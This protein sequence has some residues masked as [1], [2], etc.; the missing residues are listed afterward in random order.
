MFLW[1][2][3]PQIDGDLDN[4][5]IAHEYGH[6]ISIRLVGGPGS[7]Q[8]GGSEQMGEGWSDW[9]GLM[10]TMNNGDAG[11]DSRA[12]GNYAL[13]QGPNGGGIRPTP[14]STNTAINGTTYDDIGGLSVPHGV[15]YA[16]ATIIWDLTWALVDDQGFDTD[17]YNGT[18]G[19]NV[20]M[21][22]I[23][24]GLK[25]TANNPGFVSGR[26][27]IL[28]ADQ[29]LYGG[30][31]N[32]II[33][34]VFAARG[35]GIDANEN[36]NGGTN[37][38]TDQ[39]TS[40]V[41]GCGGGGPE[42]C[43]GTVSS[44][45][46]NESF[47][48]N[49]G[50]WTQSSNDDIDWTRDS[51]GT[52]SSNTGPSSAADGTTYI[53]VEASVNGT[54]YPNKRAILNSPC[55]DLSSATSASFNY[56]YHMFGAT[57][58]G[59]IDLEVSTDDGATWSSIW[60]Q[61]GNQGDQ[62]NAQSINLGAYTGES[63]VRLRF[64]RLTGSTWQADIALDSFNLDISGGGGGG[65]TSGVSVPYSESFESSIGVW[66][67]SLGDDIDWT[68][69]S[70]GTPSSNTGPSSGSAG[71]FYM[72][73][74]ASV[75][76]TGYPNKRAILNSP[77]I[78]L[79]SES[80]AS[81]NFD[82]HMFGATD[83]GSIALE[84]STDGSNWVSL[85]S[86]T[87]NQGNQWNSQSIDLNAYLGGTVELRFNR[88][89]GSTWQADIAIDNVSLTADGG[90]DPNPPTGYCASNGNNTNDEY[91]QRVEI[92]SI[93]NVTGASS[94]GYGD[95]TNLSTNLGA[96]N[97]ITITPL[98]TGTIYAEGYAVWVD[99][100]RDGDFGDSGELVFSQ[101]ATTDTPISGSFSVPGG[102]SAGP[103]RMR[104]SMKYNGIPSSCESFTYGEVEDYIVVIPSSIQGF[105]GNT[106]NGSNVDLGAGISI[107]PNPV[108]RGVLNVR[109]LDAQAIDY[110]IYNV[111]GQVVGSGVFTSSI[112]VSK[113]Q[114][115]MYMIQVNAET[116]QFVES[117]IVE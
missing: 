68:R 13:G 5:I 99:W 11:T 27:G 115:G 47:E 12:V 32:C 70:G 54:G 65:C 72:Y 4:L 51:G 82:Y 42:P 19:N 50:A 112:D 23:I 77:C 48:S 60:N 3:S 49:F 78:D 62:W 110:T 58:M 108:N 28:Q 102:A 64:N 116:Q 44:Y 18:G 38:N 61:T 22:L 56:S 14:Y 2:G 114:S 21:S 66:S 79:T 89:T 104:V 84:A 63:N 75:N 8:L 83:M 52:P 16:W 20:A 74:E 107:S 93:D 35:V 80:E 85:W 26:D 17:F 33:W 106:N 45:P 25:N 96:S 7:N 71:S 9:F 98:W 117:F 92:G 39:T 15:G 73:V 43:S 41:S 46:Y 31:Y 91:I 94:G 109:L 6:G 97:S 36:T 100:N 1:S 81:F 95:Y 40:F 55:F 30:Q 103:T 57:D 111:V 88:L 37:G 105:S 86:Q 34:D 24:E 76:G 113:L 29:D 101:A 69:D 67:Q 53:Y 59:S 87:G 10:L 90:G